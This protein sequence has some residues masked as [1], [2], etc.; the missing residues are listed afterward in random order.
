[1]KRN[2]FI[3]RLICIMCATVLLCGMFAACGADEENPQPTEAPTQA[4]T[5]EPGPVDGPT[6]G[7]TTGPTEEPTQE[8]TK[9]E[10]SSIMDGEDHVEIPFG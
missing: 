9:D 6:E 2:A 5:G 1:M 3:L 7:P 8:P 10:N 4:P